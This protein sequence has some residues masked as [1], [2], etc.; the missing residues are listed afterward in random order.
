[1]E[2]WKKVPNFSDY[3]V[4]NHGNLRNFHTKYKLSVKSHHD[5]YVRPGLKNDDGIKKSLSIHRMVCYLFNGKPEND[6]LT[7]DHINRIKHDNRAVN[8]R[9]VT[10]SEQQLNRKKCIKGNFKIISI[11]KQDKSIEY[12]SVKEASDKINVKPLNIYRALKHNR[13]YKDLRWE[14]KKVKNLPLEKWKKIENR[15]IF[16]SNKGRIKNKNDIEIEIIGGV[17]KSIY[18]NG[19]SFLIHRLVA[20]LFIPNPL[21]L[22]I[23]N[24]INL[25]KHDNRSENLEWITQ[26]DNCIHSRKFS[27]YKNPKSLKILK[28]CYKTNNVLNTYCSLR[29]AS[30]KENIPKTSLKRIID[31]NKVYNGFLYTI[32]T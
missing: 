15:D 11:D 16:I 2:I 9:W 21:N 5:G 13:L 32:I 26:Q 12:N 30:V 28:T 31:K 10:R 4:S 29:N 27:N 1:M 3:E 6:T 25:N 18:I 17:Y 24:H 22:E 20:E 14:Y 23:V 19:K 8:L 7:V